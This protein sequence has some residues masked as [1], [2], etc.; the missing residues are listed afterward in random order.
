MSMIFDKFKSRQRALDFKAQ[1]KRSYGLNGRIF[2]TSQAAQRCDP[3]PGRLVPLIVHIDR[4]DLE[5]ERQIER[6]A[7]R[8]GGTYVGT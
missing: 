3:F 2:S 7:R 6:L 5:V 1:V 8:F 4:A